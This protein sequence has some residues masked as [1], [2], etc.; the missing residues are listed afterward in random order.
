MAEKT[1]PNDL[2]WL[3]DSPVG[4]IKVSVKTSSSVKKKKTKPESKVATPARARK[5]IDKKHKQKSPPSKSLKRQPKKEK[6]TKKPKTGVEDDGHFEELKKD[7]A[8][9]TGVL[10][11]PNGKWRYKKGLTLAGMQKMVGGMI[12]HVPITPVVYNGVKVNVAIVNEDGMILNLPVNEVA[13]S[14]YAGDAFLG[15]VLLTHTRYL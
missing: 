2:N 8:G 13:S 15:P 7:A 6:K 3:L 12:E 9:Y 5:S 1:T 11:S 10:V 14:F 4:N